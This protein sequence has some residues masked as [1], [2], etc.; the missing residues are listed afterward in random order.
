MSKARYKV[1]TYI[2]GLNK[3]AS[4][5]SISSPR[6]AQNTMSFN[7]KQKKPEEVSLKATSRSRAKPA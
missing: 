6:Y 3:T 5:I 2:V 4:S 7:S 1:P